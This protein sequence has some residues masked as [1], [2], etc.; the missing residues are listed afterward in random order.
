MD[1]YQILNINVTASPEEIKR[2]YRRMSGKYHPDNAGEKARD[3][4]DKVQEAYVVLSD[5]E[6]R[7]AYDRILNGK[8]EN[9][10]EKDF[11]KQEKAENNY[12]DLS[13]FYRGAYQN[14]FERF[15]GFD[16]HGKEKEKAKGAAPV[17]TD[18]LFESFFGIK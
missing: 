7:A 4:F 10:Q 1:Y 15:F 14:S 3:M 5:E 11:K 9:A 8:T 17:N 6:K 18:K 2:A 16:P 12:R 13:A